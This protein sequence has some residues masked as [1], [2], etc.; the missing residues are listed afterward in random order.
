MKKSAFTAILLSI[1]ILAG[2]CANAAGQVPKNTSQAGTTDITREF[3]IQ[4]VPLYSAA[5]ND[6]MQ[7]DNSLDLGFLTEKDSVPLALPIYK[8]PYPFGMEGAL[9]EFTDSMKTALKEKLTRFLNIL[10]GGQTEQAYDIYEND[11]VPE[12]LFYDGGNTRFN[13]GVA[14]ISLS[15][16]EY[17][18]P[19]DT[20]KGTLLENALVKAAMAF[21]EIKNP[22]LH[23]KIS[24]FY[25]ETGLVTDYV[26]TITEEAD[27][28]FE[29][30]LNKSFTYITVSRF[31]SE[32]KAV[33]NIFHRGNP[34]KIGEIPVLSREA[35]TAYL[36]ETYPS[37]RENPPL[38]EIVYN[39]NIQ[40]GLFLPCYR[41]YLPESVSEGSTVYRVFYIPMTDKTAE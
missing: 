24:Y 41:V 20:E 15:T 21:L 7:L 8:N 6:L 26:Y 32:E 23:R 4:E 16:A 5:G 11:V 3:P 1:V 19:A 28:W 35:V 17:N 14:D 2:G 13:V 36:Q 30:A 37:T 22:V 12:K 40:P 25:D 31:S 18:L 39:K 34:E 38:L 33:M 27:N 9:F 10:D 29:T